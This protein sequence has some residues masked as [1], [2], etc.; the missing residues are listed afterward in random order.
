MVQVGT[1]V[2]G[3]LEVNL[4]FAPMS[5]GFRIGNQSDFGDMVSLDITATSGGNVEERDINIT[6]FADDSYDFINLAD[7]D[8]KFQI[9]GTLGDGRQQEVKIVFTWQ[10]NEA[11]HNNNGIRSGVDTDG[12]RRA[13]SVD[14]DDDNDR[15][16]D[17][18]DNCR[19][20]VNPAQNN[21]DGDTEGD[22]CDGDDDNDG[23]DDDDEE[24][25]TEQFSWSE[26][27]A[28]SGL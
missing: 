5:G 12:D 20:V 3:A 14:E 26:L 15:V 16:L 13:D 4:T 9:T 11:D 24:R 1:V 2:W 28:V 22:A 18:R 6:E 27:F 25:A 19:L 10:E 21:T 23:L 8:W 17:G 7:L